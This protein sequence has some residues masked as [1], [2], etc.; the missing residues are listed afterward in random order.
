MFITKE[1]LMRSKFCLTVLLFFSVFMCY[2]QEYSDD[3]LV[4]SVQYI[5]K[6][7]MTKI[8]KKNYCALFK[9]E[10]GQSYYKLKYRV[11]ESFTS[12]KK[13]PKIIEIFAECKYC[14]KNKYQLLFLLK[15]KHYYLYELSPIYP[16]R[17]KKWASSYDGI[18]DHI[19]IYEDELK[20][21]DFYPSVKFPLAEETIV[22]KN[23]IK[24]EGLYEI[25]DEFYYLKK[26]LYINEYFEKY[27]PS[28]L[29]RYVAE[30]NAKEINRDLL[31]N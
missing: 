31:I 10:S 21:I 18:I 16:T 1:I 15:S 30:V 3:F 29:G 25:S 11:I 5:S 13:N 20:D 19:D 6:T 26:G 9:C 24:D 17:D 23:K 27:F 12:Q 4:V 22:K 8:E 14:F 7:N 28:I 2:A